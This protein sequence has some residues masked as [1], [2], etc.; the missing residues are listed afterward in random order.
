MPKLNEIKLGLKEK[1][2][3]LINLEND[4]NLARDLW[5][6]KEMNEISI[7][8]Y[9][10]QIKKYNAEISSLTNEI[11]SLKETGKNI[12]PGDIE[13]I[14][15]IKKALDKEENKMNE[16]KLRI[17]ELSTK[18]DISKKLIDDIAKLDICPV[19][20]QIV[21]HN[22]KKTIVARE[23]NIIVKLS[24]NMEILSK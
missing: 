5:K 2:E 10:G 12:D 4:I 11:N 20:K 7:R 14:G 9:I 16:I 1:R 6:N 22:H 24:E 13:K 21:D 8:H 18:E 3:K 23:N 15:E 19:C 17:N